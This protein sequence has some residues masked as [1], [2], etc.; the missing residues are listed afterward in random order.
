MSDLLL[1]RVRAAVGHLYDVEAEVGRGGAGVVYRARDVRLRRWVALKV[2]PPDLGFRAGV[3]QRF[4][5]EAETA[6]QLSHPNIVPI[7]SVDEVDGLVYFAMALVEGESLAARLAREPRPPLRV[8]RRVLA[9]V[10]DALAC[11]HARGVIHRDVKPDNILLDPQGSPLVTDFGIARATEE[12]GRLTVTGV[13]IGT[14]AYM[15]PEQAL[16]ERELD[17][18]SDIY[19]LGVVG[20][21]ML[22]GEPPFTA[23]NTPAMLMKQLGETP[24]PLGRRRPDAPAWLVGAV[25]RAMEKKASHRWPDAAAFRA[26]LAGDAAAAA[27]PLLPPAA[28][29]EERRVW[30]EQLRERQRLWREQQQSWRPLPV[31]AEKERAKPV[32]VRIRDARASIAGYG[33]TTLGFAGINYLTSPDF[34]WFLFPAFGM[35][36]GVLAQM[37]SLWADGIGLRHVLRGP[38]ALAGAAG[39]LPAAP[40]IRLAEPAPAPPVPPTTSRRP[41]PPPAIA[42]GGLTRRVE[43]FRRWAATAAGFG[44]AAVASGGAFTTLHDGFGTEWVHALEPFIALSSVGVLTTGA[45]VARK[46]RALRRAG[47]RLRDLLTDGWRHAVG[48]ADPAVGAQLLAEETAKLAAPEVLAGA[49]GAHVRRA[50]EDR[51]TIFELLHKLP[52]PDRALIPDVAPTVNALVARVASLAASLHRLDKDVSPE[53]LDRTEGRVA[54]AERERAVQGG[55]AGADRKLALLQRQRETL[56]DLLQRRATFVGQLESAGLALQNVRFDLV[57]LRSSG[58]ASVGEVTQATQEARALSRDIERVLE[59][60]A[61]VRAL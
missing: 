17:G 41:A 1:E 7:Y 53:M 22:A 18:R 42:G 31:A 11:A 29:P 36:I 38:A 45:V 59:A 9:G 35:G 39:P 55:G 10:A 58:V 46:A 8:V 27:V 24:R 40:G 57:K 49:Y 56:R 33:A 3:R 19:S 60:A 28:P 43:S 21:E 48:A 54:E 23:A 5:R 50:A 12:D 2:L 15:S 37:G 14:P 47:L 44:V 52:A 51:A 34:P 20:Y 25:E 32:E 26:A 6:A 4:L 61:E 13:A 30:K 16:G